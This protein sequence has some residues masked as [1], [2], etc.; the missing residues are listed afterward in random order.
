MHRL[1][2]IIFDMDGTLTQT[3]QLIYDSFNFIAENYLHKRFTPPEITAFF[4]PPEKE[5]IENMIGPEHIGDAMKEYY[6]FYEERHNELAALYPGIENIL[7]FVK[8]QQMLIGLFT[9]KGRRTTEIT[10]KKF[11]IARY[12]DI[13][14]TGDDVKNFKPSS[15]GIRKIMRRFSLSPD[16]VLM[17][18]DAV[19]D[20][21]ASHDAGVKIAAVLWDSY[22]KEKVLQI[23]KTPLG[24][25]DFVFHDVVEFQSWLTSSL[26]RSAQA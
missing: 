12:F 17:V 1:K 2:C 15:E 11:R 7:Q 21:K 16:E 9:G 24:E 6:R 5:A 22:G 8:S 3:N 4:G 10:L 19:A 26:D 23:L 25:T 13:V 14:V 18:G 20:V